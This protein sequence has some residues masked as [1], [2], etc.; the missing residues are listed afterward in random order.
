M[1]KHKIS[2]STRFFPHKE[3]YKIFDDENLV[4]KFKIF[5]Q[6]FVPIRTALRKRKFENCEMLLPFK[7]SRLSVA[8]TPLSASVLFVTGN[9]LVYGIIQLEVLFLMHLLGKKI[10][11]TRFDRSHTIGTHYLQC[12]LFQLKLP[13][14][15]I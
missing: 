8:L 6:D 9:T 4:E 7:S 12:G 1:P 13:Y 10:S 3:R 15:S 14:C 5:V 11:L 2:P